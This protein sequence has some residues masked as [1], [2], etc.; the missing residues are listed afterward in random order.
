MS[1]NVAAIMEDT[2]SRATI[3]QI[4]EAMSRDTVVDKM[5]EAAQTVEDLYQ[6]VMRYG[7]MK[8][9]EFKALCSDV[10]DYFRG[11]KVAL[12]DEIMDAVVGGG[13]WGNLWNKCKTVVAAVGAGIVVGALAAGLVLSAA[14]LAL[15]AAA[16]VGVVAGVA[17]GVFLYKPIKDQMES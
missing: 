8:F 3:D 1:I 2:Q 15:T 11:P 7:S 14:P 4:Q 6:V 5:I 12:D 13:F 17:G 16:V 9:E 10:M